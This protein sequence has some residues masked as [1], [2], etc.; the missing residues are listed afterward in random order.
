MTALIIGYGNELRRDDGAGPAV[1]R[2]VADFDIDGVLVATA[3]QLLPEHCEAIA[4]AAMVVFVDA[5][6]GDPGCVSVRRL[7]AADRASWSPHRCHPAALLALAGHL[8]GN[9]PDAWI[10]TVP[11]LDLAL[12]EGLSPRARD[13]VHEAA[14]RILKLLECEHPECRSAGRSK[15]R[16]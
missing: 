6:L 3:H 1:A 2:A 8:Y 14:H 11:A 7:Q 9:I 4:A 15:S 5:C 13:G 10:V 12:G 16:G